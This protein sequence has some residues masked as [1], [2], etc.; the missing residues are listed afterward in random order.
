MDS[1][2][3]LLP[4]GKTRVAGFEPGKQ[5]LSVHGTFASPLKRGKRAQENASRYFERSL[6]A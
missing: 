6:D 3:D 2:P 4:G 5:A 1:T